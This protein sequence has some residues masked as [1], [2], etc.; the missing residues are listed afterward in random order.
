MPE[1]SP[2]DGWIDRVVDRLSR[3]LTAVGLN[4]TRLRWKWSQRRLQMAEARAQREQLLK[5]ARGRHKM[6]PSCRALVP[7]TVTTCPDCGVSMTDVSTPGIGRLVVNLFPGV[8]AATSLLM[9]INGF[10]FLLMIMAQMKSGGGQMSPLG[11]FSFEL[12]IRFGS[13]INAPY[14][15]PDGQVA[16]GEWWRWI[17]P[18]FLHGGLLHFFFN[19]YLLFQLG[20]LL[21][22]EL[23][24]TRFWPVY[25]GCGISGSLFSQ[26]LRPAIPFMNPYVNTVGASG[27]IMGLIGLLLVHGIRSGSPIGLAVRSMLWRLIFYSVVLSLFF[28]IDHLAHVGGF[29]CGALLALLVPTGPFRSR[30]AATAWQLLSLVGVVLVL[31]AFYQVAAQGR[32]AG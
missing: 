11:G 3:V 7:R 26:V 23:G 2:H 5:S 17:T 20:P 8:T 28:N 30:Q 32:L 13:G 31:Y 25:L 18:I 12:S 29:L 10:W 22:A 16:G 4:G 21:E 1:E 9:L 24:T 27:A 6:C 14:T 19:S 15:F